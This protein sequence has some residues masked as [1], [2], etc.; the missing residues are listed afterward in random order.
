MIKV[1]LPYVSFSNNVICT[2]IG[3]W[4]STFIAFHESIIIFVSVGFFSNIVS[5]SFDDLSFITYFNNIKNNVLHHILYNLHLKCNFVTVICNLHHVTTHKAITGD[6][7]DKYLVSRY[8]KNVGPPKF[9]F[10]YGLDYQTLP[11]VFIFKIKIVLID[12]LFVLSF[13]RTV[14]N[15]NKLDINTIRYKNVFFNFLSNFYF[16]YKYLQFTQL[17]KKLKI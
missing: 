14:C 11:N 16:A 9:F 12:F 6:K 15:N 4:C 17:C 13:S 7:N 5:L 2:Y 10:S 8:L 3:D 1:I